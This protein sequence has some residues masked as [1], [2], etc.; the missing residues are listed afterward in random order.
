MTVS[1]MGVSYPLCCT[2]CRD[3]FN[4][5]PQKYLKKLALMRESASKGTPVKAATAPNKDDGAFDGLTDE[6]KPQAKTAPRAKMAPKDA[7]K[8]DAPKPAAPKST[9]LSRAA[10]LL[11]LGQNLEKLGKISGAL[12]YYG[13][14][15]KEYPD[16]PHAQT[17]AARIK[18]L[19]D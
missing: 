12:G 3:E 8:A 9:D 16:T 18:A 6:P 5:N 15:V 13:R 19:K 4:E 1:Y 14:V 10:S 2:G 7:P 11:R 17:A